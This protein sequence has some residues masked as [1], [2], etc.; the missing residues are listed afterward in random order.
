MIF[1][2]L[3][4]IFSILKNIFKVKFLLTIMFS[5]LIILV[6]AK[7]FNINLDFFFFFAVI[8]AIILIY[9]P[10]DKY[11]APNIAKMI[12]KFFKLNKHHNHI[13]FIIKIFTR[14]IMWYNGGLSYYICIYL[15]DF[16]EYIDIKPIYTSIEKNILEPIY[17]SKIFNIIKNIIINSNTL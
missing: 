15:C 2:L 11:I 7:F 13:T 10:Y 8:P 6:L 17:N 14:L 12:M 4:E 5:S 3:I 9:K 16:I 1:I